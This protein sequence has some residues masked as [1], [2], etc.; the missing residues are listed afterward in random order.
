VKRVIEKD[1]A[2]WGAV[3]LTARAGRWFIESKSTEALAV[4]IENQVIQVGWYW[5]AA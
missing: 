5:C 4:L 2:G 1:V 3:H